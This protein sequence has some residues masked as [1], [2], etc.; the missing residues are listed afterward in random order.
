VNFTPNSYEGAAIEGWVEVDCPVRYIQHALK[1]EAS[2]IYHTREV[3]YNHLMGLIVF[4]ELDPDKLAA[5]WVRL[6]NNF[7]EFFGFWWFLDEGLA[8]Q[9]IIL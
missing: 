1:Q 3:F 7:V 9:N 5:G 4:G 8:K 2:A 6:L